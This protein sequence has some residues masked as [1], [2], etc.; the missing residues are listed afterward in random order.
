MSARLHVG[1]GAIDDPDYTEYTD[2]DNVVIYPGVNVGRAT[3]TTV[4]LELVGPGAPEDL[5]DVEKTIVV[6][7]Y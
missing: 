3:T 5:I 6:S 7:A 4:R 1:I 2:L